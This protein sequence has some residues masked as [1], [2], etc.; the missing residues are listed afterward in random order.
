MELLVVIALIALLAAL[1]MPVL[2]SA[3]EAARRTACLGHLRQM[4]MAWQTYA[5]NNDSRIVC[6]MPI[7]WAEQ[8]IDKPW[9]TAGKP[10]LIDGGLSE[11]DKAQTREGADVVMRTGALASYIGNVSIYRCP[12]RRKLLDSD[13]KYYQW[14]SAYGIVTPMNCFS[15]SWRVRWEA[16]FVEWHGSNPIPVC[17]TK[18]SQ[19]SPPGPAGRMVFLDV[20]SPSLAVGNGPAD[21]VIVGNNPTT[22]SGWTVL[23]PGPPLHHAE[24]TCTSFADGHGQYW[25]W[26]DPRTVA[27]SRA[28][29]DWYDSGRAGPY[30][31]SPPFPPDPD[32]HDYLEFYEAI[33]G[34]R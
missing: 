29:R 1:L 17:I 25:K 22:K 16:E 4:Q 6:G 11:V 30:P 13:W 18:L 2:H 20:G 27:W 7:R 24:G 5:E 32:N 3:R 31:E 26:K 28:W 15:V 19:L 14:L 10:W 8:G 33:W 12:S 9:Q 21:W 23:G 34:R